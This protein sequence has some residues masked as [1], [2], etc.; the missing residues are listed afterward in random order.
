VERTPTQAQITTIAI[1]DRTTMA[2][3]GPERC[4]R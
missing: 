4:Q 3:A 1:T 2:I